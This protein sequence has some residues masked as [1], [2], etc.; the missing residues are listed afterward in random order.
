MFT[1]YFIFPVHSNVECPQSIPMYS[2]PS[3]FQCVMY[4]GCRLKWELEDFQTDLEEAKRNLAEMVTSETL[5]EGNAGILV[6]S[7]A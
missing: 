1:V 5:A 2:V 3:P 6:N 4:T 7:W